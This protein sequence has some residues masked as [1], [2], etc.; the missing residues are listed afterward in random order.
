MERLIEGFDRVAV[1][2]A[3]E[4]Q[5]ALIEEL[6]RLDELLLLRLAEAAQLRQLGVDAEN[7]GRPGSELRQLLEFRCR[8]SDVAVPQ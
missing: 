7:V 4:Q 5:H 8:G 1:L 3:V 6:L 2:L